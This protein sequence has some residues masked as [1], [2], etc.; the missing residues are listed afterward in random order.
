MHVFSSNR[1]AFF[2]SFSIAVEMDNANPMDNENISFVMEC[3]PINIKVIIIDILYSRSY[4]N[5]LK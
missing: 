3:N 2:F 4:I 1:I 5:F